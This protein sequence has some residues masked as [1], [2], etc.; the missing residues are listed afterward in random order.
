MSR[1]SQLNRKT[2]ETDIS[3]KLDIDG[4]GEGKISTGVGF[5]DHLLDALRKHGQFD[6]DISAIGD[7]HIDAHHT[8]EDTG[9]IF[10]QAFAGALG[11]CSGIT[12]FGHAFCPLDEALAR[13]V[14]DISGRGFLHFENPVKTE[15]VGQFDGELFRE[16][17][18]AFA[19]N[20]KITLHVTLLY[21]ENQHHSMEAMIKAV[22]RA[23]RMAVTIDNELSGIPSTKGVL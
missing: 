15:K 8:V 4:K 16:F 21:G 1:K 6:M 9:I 11:D 13:A 2:N 17:L 12:R 3:V 23:L 7:L 20:A 19:I 18:R 10:G 22:A 14:V 5:F